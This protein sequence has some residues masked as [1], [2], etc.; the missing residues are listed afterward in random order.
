[1][2]IKFIMQESLPN[3][4]LS[5][6]KACCGNSG[7]R[8]DAVFLQGPCSCVRFVIRRSQH[9]RLRYSVLVWHK[10]GLLTIASSQQDI[11]L[12]ICICMDVESN[13]GPD[14]RFECESHTTRLITYTKQDLLRLRKF[15]ASRMKPMPAVVQKLKMFNLYR[16][17]GCWGGSWRRELGV[18]V[19]KVS[20]GESR[21]EKS[22]P[23]ISS[24]RGDVSSSI[25]ARDMKNLVPIPKRNQ[26]PVLRTVSEF[27]VPKFLFKNICS[28]AKTKNKVRAAVALEADLNNKDI[29]VYCIRDAFKTRN[30]GCYH[31][32]SWLFYFQM[33]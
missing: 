25:R 10:H 29:D 11:C 12:D 8:D 4:L 2:V 20:S 17:R 32:H 21:D 31:Q 33:G 15:P 9:A 6:R 22:I 30:A 1:M 14:N 23:V 27:A 24:I 5:V 3:F 13:P 16:Y 19:G 26:N 18:D 28:L 7:V